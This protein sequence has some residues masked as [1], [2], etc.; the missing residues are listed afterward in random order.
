MS[1]HPVPDKAAL[2]QFGLVLALILAVIFGAVPLWWLGKPPLLPVMIAAGVLLLWALLLPKTL[3]PLYR[4]WMAIGEVLGWIN[5]R[6][7]LG[8]L[9]VALFFPVG[10]LMKLLGK[11]PMRRRLDA[12]AASYR[13]PSNHQPREHLERPY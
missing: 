5:T 8:I 7:I 9:F 13:N 3:S 11:D 6:I 12:Q 2:R 4:L 10:L 1:K